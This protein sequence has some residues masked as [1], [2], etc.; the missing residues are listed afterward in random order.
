MWGVKINNAVVSN[1]NSMYTFRADL[2]NCFGLDIGVQGKFHLSMEGFYP[3]YNHFDDIRDEDFKKASQS[4]CQK[5]GLWD[6]KMKD[7]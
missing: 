6:E 3:E 2:E 4:N 7:E 5:F 1:V